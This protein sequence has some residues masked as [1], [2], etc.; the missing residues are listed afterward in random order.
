MIRRFLVR[1]LIQKNDTDD[2]HLENTFYTIETKEKK[3]KEKK[4]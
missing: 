3:R 2:K 1:I 4:G